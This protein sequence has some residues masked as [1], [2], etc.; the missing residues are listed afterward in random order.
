MKKPKFNQYL[1]ERRFHGDIS[2]YK[3]KLKTFEKDF[4][5]AFNYI[6]VF[7][8]QNII[9]ENYLDKILELHMAK[10]REGFNGAAF[11]SLLLNGRFFSIHEKQK[12][13]GDL[14]K[15]TFL[16][17]KLVKAKE[18]KQI[19]K[20]ISEVISHRNIIAHN[21]FG[22]HVESKNPIF[23]YYERGRLKEFELTTKDMT[24]Y[25][26]KGN[27][28]IEYLKAFIVKLKEHEGE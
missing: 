6:G 16:F 20:L 1:K 8:N 11:K 4:E 21:R 5:S 14:T 19:R 17:F 10:N 22:I 27:Q 3:G 15:S 25:L 2:D 24:E 26:E 9:I 7:L 23:K 18:A 28:I 12:M 13:F